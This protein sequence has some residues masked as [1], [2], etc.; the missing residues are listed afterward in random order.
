MTTPDQTHPQRKEV[1]LL[2]QELAVRKEARRLCNA[3]DSSDLFAALE[4][5]KFCSSQA[6]KYAHEALF[7]FLLPGLILFVVC[8]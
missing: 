3:L 7:F 1:I 6:A 5:A 8:A 2:P 4:A